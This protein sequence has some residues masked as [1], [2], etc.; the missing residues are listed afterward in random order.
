MKLTKTA[1]LLFLSSSILMFLC[2]YFFAKFDGLTSS[3]VA[4]GAGILTF[5]LPN[6]K[7]VK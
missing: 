1:L 4:I 6:L 2:L 3:F 7:K 5:I